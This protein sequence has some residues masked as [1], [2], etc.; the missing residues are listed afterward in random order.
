MCT[1]QGSIA[2][3][4]KMDASTLF[5]VHKKE[6]E[7]KGKNIHIKVAIECLHGSDHGFFF[8]KGRK[9]LASHEADFFP[10][11]GVEDNAKQNCAAPKDCGQGQLMRAPQACSLGPCTPSPLSY[12]SGPDWMVMQGQTTQV[13]CSMCP[14]RSASFFFQNSYVGQQS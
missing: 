13:S 14:F 6:G 9:R 2:K 12:T 8:K 3:S 10:A 11:G 4:K 1:S 7:G 5:L